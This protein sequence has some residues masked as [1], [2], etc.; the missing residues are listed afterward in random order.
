MKEVHTS[1]PVPDDLY[2]AAENFFDQ[3]SEEEQLLSKKPAKV[4]KKTAIN[5][6]QKWSIE[7][8][9]E[10]KERFKKSFRTQTRPTPSMVEKIRCLSQ[11]AGGC[12]HKRSKDTL[13]KKIFRMV[14]S[15]KK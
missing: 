15:L 14:D 7:E 6:K 13:K 2:D 9:E 12:I 8:E 10:I 4:K 5:T 11:M 3:D 1:Q